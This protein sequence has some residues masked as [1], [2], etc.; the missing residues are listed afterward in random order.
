MEAHGEQG[1]QGCTEDGQLGRAA[2]VDGQLKRGPTL[3]RVDIDAIE[4]GLREADV[5]EV[6]IVG[7]Q[8]V[9]VG[10]RRKKLNGE[11]PNRKRGS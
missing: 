3:A 7:G 11:R 2:T 6:K 10:I 1:I 5:V 8:I 9:V 4:R